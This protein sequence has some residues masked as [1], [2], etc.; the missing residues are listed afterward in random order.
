[1]MDVSDIEM[2]ACELAYENAHGQKLGF[3][4]IPEN[5]RDVILKEIRAR[6]L[7][8]EQHVTHDMLVR[9]IGED[10]WMPQRFMIP[11]LIT[12]VVMAALI[13]IGLGV[14]QLFSSR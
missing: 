7:R 11:A 2:R 8:I 9:K 5:E 6:V 14:M 13:F 4:E 10:R 1:M 3:A 12:A